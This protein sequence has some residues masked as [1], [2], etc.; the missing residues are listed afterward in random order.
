MAQSG[1]DRS[2]SEGCNTT[3]VPSAPFVPTAIEAALLDA[4]SK[5][6][7]DIRC[8]AL[9]SI[10]PAAPTTPPSDPGHGTE[11]ASGADEHRQI[12]VGQLP[13][14]VQQEWVAAILN[15]VHAGGTGKAPTDGPAVSSVVRRSSGARASPYALVTLSSAEHVPA[16]RA[17]NRCIYVGRRHL[18]FCDPSTASLADSPPVL[19][20]NPS[21]SGAAPDRTTTPLHE[22]VG[23]LIAAD[24][25]TSSPET[26]AHG[27]ARACVVVGPANPPPSRP[28]NGDQRGAHHIQHGRGGGIGARGSAPA[29]GQQHAA[30]AGRRTATFAPQQQFHPQQM[31]Q[32][33]YAAPQQQ[34][35][36]ASQPQFVQLG[37]AFQNGQ[38]VAQQHLPQ[39]QQQ[40]QQPQYVLLP[41]GTLA[42]LAPQQPAVQ[43]A[44]MAQHAQQP[45]SQPQAFF[46]SHHH[47]QSP[48]PQ[49]QQ[50]QQQPSPQTQQAATV[51]L[52]QPGAFSLN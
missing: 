7:S 28:A 21:K 13:I 5:P 36:A 12:F 22:I 51:P 33:V 2:S 50:Q 24:T 1:S 29:Y 14:F 48:Q 52:L 42:M 41:D 15:F 45:Q 46:Q 20:A 32:V 39:Q 17:L 38:F 49:Q 19:V 23:P 6:D 10:V 26:R 37:S 27:L 9:T 34:M 40:Q 35:F 31:P 8:V 3:G 25:A 47:H 18:F 11:P 43:F 44:P 4:A 30:A 16:F